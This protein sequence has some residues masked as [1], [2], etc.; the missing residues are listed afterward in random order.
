MRTSV[1]LNDELSSYVDAV[2]SSAGENDA[3]AIRETIRHAKAQDDRVDELESRVDELRTELDERESRIDA[4]ETALNEKDARIDEL[5]TTI[6][7]RDARVDELQ[8]DVDDRD[9]RID[10]LK[11]RLDERDARVDEL[12]TDVERL[13]NEKRLI[14]E[15]RE[16]KEE[17]VKYVEDE[18]TVEQRW[19][20]ATALKRM[21][22]R[23]FG[24]DSDD[25]E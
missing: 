12:Q 15:E 24:M 3:E 1:S 4:V 9:A 22:W 11:T 2:S 21:K 5:Q 25:D 23:L 18:R 20:E 16:E 8:T 17:L 13:Q 6:D 14:L 7:E 19:R 10:E